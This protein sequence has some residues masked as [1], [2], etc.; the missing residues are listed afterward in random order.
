MLSQAD[1]KREMIVGM[2]SPT[3][4]A[5]QKSIAHETHCWRKSIQSNKRVAVLL[6][7]LLVDFELDK[8]SGVITK[9]D[10]FC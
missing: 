7:R 3:Q 6:F 5:D 10:K 1:P 4:N 9:H 2:Q 8:V